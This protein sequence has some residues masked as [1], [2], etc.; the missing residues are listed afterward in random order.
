MNVKAKKTKKNETQCNRLM[1]DAV[2]SKQIYLKLKNIIMYNIKKITPAN[3]LS[4]MK[5]MMIAGSLLTLTSCL[6]NDDDF[7]PQQ[8]A[9]VS[10][11]HASPGTPAFNF[12]TD[13]GT[14]NGPFA[15]GQRTL[16]SLFS[17][18]QRKV[19]IRKV[20][21]TQDTLRTGTLNLEAD[22]YY[23]VYVVDAAPNPNFLV[24]KDSLSSP[25]AGKAK[26]RFIN[27]SPDAGNLSLTTGTDSVLFNATAY[28]T[29]TLFNEIPGNKNYAFK[30]KLN[31]TQK[32][33]KENI[34]IKS[35]RIY[36]IWARGLD[37]TTND[38]LKTSVQ[39]SE[40]LSD[41]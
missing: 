38:T 14:G 33:I 22:K 11:F 17:A 2:M 34:E 6:K 18:G 5:T 15:F 12:I 10:I 23:S 40:H 32:A 3:R 9:A 35:G 26:I 7:T 1:I 21:G 25:A 19:S 20:G 24:I 4:F 36:T 8:V 30:I 37:N 41:F 28:K 16:Y 29:H 27:L 31:D 13:R 39:V